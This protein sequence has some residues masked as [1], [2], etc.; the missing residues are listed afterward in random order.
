MNPPATGTKGNRVIHVAVVE[1][2]VLVMDAVLDKLKDLPDIK[3]VGTA[4]HGSQLHELVRTKSPDV[5]VLDIGMATGNFEPIS[6]VRALLRSFPNVQILILTGYSNTTLIRELVR[7]GARGY[8]LKSDDLSTHLPQ[9]VRMLYDGK[10]F[11]SPVV[12]DVLL[13]ED[14]R[15]ELTEREREA[16]CLLAKGYQNQR[17]A[18]MLGV[19]TNRIRNLLSVVYEKLGISESD[20]S[21]N[22]RVMAVNKAHEIG[23]ILEN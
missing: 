1:D 5:V 17:I 19:S 8:V 7:A 6:A 15:L 13:S 14:D 12:S 21:I 4:N 10:K 16:L 2:H 3:V 22:P 20:Q 9:A 18:E 11:F 23:L